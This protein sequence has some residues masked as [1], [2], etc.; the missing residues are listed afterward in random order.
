MECARRGRILK[1]KALDVVAQLA[2]RRRGRSAR[3]P[4]SHH[5]DF[6]LA[7]VR[8]IHQLHLEL[9]LSQAFSIG[10]LG[11][12]ASSARGVTASTAGSVSSSIRFYKT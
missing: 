2:Q 5:D 3:Q 1:A 11:I 7:L 10:P 6:V 12:R 8:R 4:G 9:V